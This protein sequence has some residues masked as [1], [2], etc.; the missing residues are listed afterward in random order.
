MALAVI[1]VVVAVDTPAND[2]VTQ[3]LVMAKPNDD[4]EK[5]VEKLHAL[6]L[7]GFKVQSF[8]AF[9]R[10]NQQVISMILFKDDRP[11]MDVYAPGVIPYSDKIVPSHEVIQRKHAF[12]EFVV[13]ID[14]K[15]FKED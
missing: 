4:T 11:K 14:D 2:A 8:G 5:Q 6:L 7:N 3:F 9:V 10:G 15:T 1:E 12:D 13:G